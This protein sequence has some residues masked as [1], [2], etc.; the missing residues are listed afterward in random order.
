M[1]KLIIILLCLCISDSYAQ[2]LNG[3]VTEN[4]TDRP[5]FPV[6]VVNL[7]TQ[8]ATYTSQK[9]YYSIQA[10]A[11]DKIAYSYIGYK[12]LQR[13]MPVSIG[14]YNI[15]VQLET[16]NYRLNE[17]ILMPDYTEYQVDSIERNKTYRPFLN[18]TKSSP[19]SSPFS[20]VAEKFNKRSKQIFRFKKNFNEWESERFV[21]TKYTPELVAEMT[22]MSGDSVGHFMNAYSMPYDYARTASDLEIKMWIRYNHKKWLKQVDTAGLPE[23]N[24]KLLNTSEQ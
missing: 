8:K 15:D 22:G 20:F 24:E 1:N 13:Q 7:R 18:R 14:S 3:R 10:L 21:D 5:L 9:G 6:T 12:T 19:I 23:I 17:I 2:T 16:V 4:G 11:G